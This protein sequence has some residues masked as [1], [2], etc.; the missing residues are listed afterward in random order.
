[1]CHQKPLNAIDPAKRSCIQLLNRSIF[2]WDSHL[3]ECLQTVALWAF[4]YEA[5]AALK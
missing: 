1:M 3:G 2:Q 4:E 5:Q